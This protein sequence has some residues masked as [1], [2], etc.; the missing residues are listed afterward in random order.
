MGEKLYIRSP[1]REKNSD[2]KKAT[3]G[4]DINPYSKRVPPRPIGLGIGTILAPF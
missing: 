3:L 2:F 4:R 1:E